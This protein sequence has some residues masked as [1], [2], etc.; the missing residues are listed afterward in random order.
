MIDQTTTFD[1]RCRQPAPSAA[2]QKKYIPAEDFFFLA[3]RAR[4]DRLV[5]ADSTTSSPSVVK[6]RVNPGS[7]FEAITQPVSFQA[8]I[9]LTMRQISSDK[10]ARD[11][12]AAA[13]LLCCS[14]PVLKACISVGKKLRSSIAGYARKSLKT[15]ISKHPTHAKFRAP[16]HEENTNRPRTIFP[17]GNTLVTRIR[18]GSLAKSGLSRT[19]E[20]NS[21]KIRLRE[22]RRRHTLRWA[23]HDSQAG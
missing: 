3:E 18:P 20:H 10:L 21:L 8:E 7:F 23:E 22:C 17:K 13:M 11:P 12:A 2:G 9:Q 6:K 4:Y 16:I 5:L 14:R 15:R 19:V 1:F